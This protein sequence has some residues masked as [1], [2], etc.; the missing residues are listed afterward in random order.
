MV[1]FFDLKGGCRAM[2]KVVQGS[3][4]MTPTTKLLETHWLSWS[5]GPGNSGPS[6]VRVGCQW[7]CSHYPCEAKRWL[8]DRRP[9]TDRYKTALLNF[10]EVAIAVLRSLRR[11]NERFQ[12]LIDQQDRFEFSLCFRRQLEAHTSHI[13]DHL[14]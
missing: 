12:V 4:T 8:T 14:L 7:Q 11:A 13:R 2:E 10:R 1:R 9:R 6:G 5:Q 3:P